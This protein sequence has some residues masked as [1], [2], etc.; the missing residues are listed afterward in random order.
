VR[1][2]KETPWDPIAQV[3]AELGEAKFEV[4]MVTAP[5]DAAARQRR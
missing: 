4:K 5:I 1:A 3:V 2:D